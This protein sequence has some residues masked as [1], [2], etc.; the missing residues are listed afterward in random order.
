MKKTI[1]ASVIAFASVAATSVFAA[2]AANVGTMDLNFSGTV[3]TTTCGLEAT[4]NGVTGNNNITLGQT[5]PNTLGV[6]VDVI[7]KPTADSKASCQAGVTDFVMQWD[8]VGSAF[9]NGGLK[10]ARGAAS[11]S[12]VQVKATN[13]KVN[14]NVLAEKNGQQ[15]E[16][17]ADTVNGEGLKYSVALMGGNVVGDM[18]ATAQVKHWYK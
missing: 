14:N 17:G 7:F 18:E 12:H 9:E 1:I 3:S 2:P 6:P 11:D 16:F 8:G 13:A 10:A 5:N 4:V 15:Y